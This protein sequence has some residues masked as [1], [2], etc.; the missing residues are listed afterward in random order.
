M[1][2]LRLNR[3]RHGLGTRVQY[4]CHCTSSKTLMQPF[5]PAQGRW[6]GAFPLEP[7]HVHLVSS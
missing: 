5:S 2:T 6:E 4:W 7:D 1:Q 3:T